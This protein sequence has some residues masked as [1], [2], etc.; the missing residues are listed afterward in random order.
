MND[1]T[2]EEIPTSVVS[3]DA[4]D[5]EQDGTKRSQRSRQ[6]S[7]RL[8]DYELMPDSTIGGAIELA[9]LALFVESKPVSLEEAMNEVKW[10]DAMK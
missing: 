2:S 8:Q 1:S 9:H 6:L 7:S 3:A 10:I 4:T 5:T